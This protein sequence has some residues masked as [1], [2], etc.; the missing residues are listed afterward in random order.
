MPTVLATVRKDVV[1]KAAAVGIVTDSCSA[2]S[3]GYGSTVIIFRIIFVSLVK[4]GEQRR[5]T[6]IL[7]H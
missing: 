6:I 4:R 7:K 5:W 1:I 2:V 3:S